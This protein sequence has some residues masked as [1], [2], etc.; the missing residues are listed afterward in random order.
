MPPRTNATN[1]IYAAGGLLIL[2]GPMQFM[3]GHTLLAVASPIL[4][5]IL[6]IQRYLR[7]RRPPRA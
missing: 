1:I 3:I 5:M 7:N 6:I 2:N 4:G